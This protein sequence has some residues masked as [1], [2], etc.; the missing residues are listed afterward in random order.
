LKSHC[1]FISVYSELGKGT[2]FKI[3]LPATASEN[4]VEKSK[5]EVGPTQG[6]G[7]Q[8]LIV[9]DEPNILR[10]TR[11]V[12]EKYNYRVLSASDGPEAL[13]FFAQQM[14][15]IGCVL[16]DISMP[17]MD[18]VALV[19]ALKKMKPDIP[20]IVSTGQSD[21][22]S[23]AELE[24]LGV[25]KFLT[26]PYNT[27]KLLTAVRDTLTDNKTRPRTSCDPGRAQC[28]DQIPCDANGEDIAPSRVHS[29]AQ[30]IAPPEST[31]VEPALRTS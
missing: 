11:M 17:Y 18:G 22:P 24:S 15:V 31:G 7:E 29:V 26:K 27:K 6:N 19:R 12:F 30:E 5:S 16:T 23:Y 3:F 28:L 25:K 4:D 9:D 8:I 21:Q 1:G 2:T 20:I 10:M 13:A 14:P